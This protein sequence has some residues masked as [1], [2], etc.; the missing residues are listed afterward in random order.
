[1]SSQLR[2][3]PGDNKPICLQNRCNNATTTTLYFGLS[4]VT[5][6]QQIKL[7]QIIAK[8]SLKTLPM[9]FLNLGGEMMYILDQRLRAQNIPKEKSKKGEFLFSWF[10]KI[11][12]LLDF[13]ALAHPVE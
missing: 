2:K 12:V 9:L 4:L 8:M 3:E 11:F 10:W 1:M 5:E 7:F 6:N 13:A